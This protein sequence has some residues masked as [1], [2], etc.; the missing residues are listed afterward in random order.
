MNEDGTCDLRLSSLDGKGIEMVG[1]PWLE[2]VELGMVVLRASVESA[3]ASGVPRSEFCEAYE[4][5]WK[6]H[7]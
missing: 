2:M 7:A 3:I 4:A 6:E 5:A 1:M